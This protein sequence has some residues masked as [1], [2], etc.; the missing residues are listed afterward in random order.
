MP[1][2]SMSFRMFANAV[3]ETNVCLVNELTANRFWLEAVDLDSR[4]MTKLELFE[5]EDYIKIAECN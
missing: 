2:C 5:R 1:C 4:F 3:C